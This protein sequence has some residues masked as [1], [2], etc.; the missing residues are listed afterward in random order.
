MNFCQNIM[1]DYI[2][3]HSTL[4]YLN[5]HLYIVKLII[6]HYFMN[7]MIYKVINNLNNHDCVQ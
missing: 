2:I 1:N 4:S 5:K 3:I 6:Q 7:N